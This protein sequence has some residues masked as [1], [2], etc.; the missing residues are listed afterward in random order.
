M[1]WIKEDFVREAALVHLDGFEIR[2]HDDVKKSTSFSRALCKRL[3][4][5][6]NSTGANKIKH[7]VAKF[8]V[9]REEV[10]TMAEQLRVAPDVAEPIDGQPQQDRRQAALTRLRE[11]FR[12]RANQPIIKIERED[13][14]IEMVFRG[15]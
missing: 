15:H 3:H 14:N 8:N 10:A 12:E 9:T 2:F 11:L 5:A 6:T 1:N 4:I 7:F 13:E